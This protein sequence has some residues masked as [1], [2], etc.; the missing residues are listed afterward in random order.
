LPRC[1]GILSLST[2]ATGKRLTSENDARDVL[3]LAVVEEVEE[4]RTRQA[5]DVDDGAVDT[6]Q[7]VLDPNAV[8]PRR[9][10]RRTGNLQTGLE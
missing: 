1:L 6:G 9:N 7:L 8:C 4:K 5:E 3:E 10:K 2:T